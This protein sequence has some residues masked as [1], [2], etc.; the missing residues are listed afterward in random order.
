MESYFTNL[1]IPPEIEDFPYILP[2]VGGQLVVR[3]V[4]MANLTRSYDAIQWNRIRFKFHLLFGNI[5]IPGPI[6]PIPG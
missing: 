5:L 2:P 1:D 4:A 6:G 3:E